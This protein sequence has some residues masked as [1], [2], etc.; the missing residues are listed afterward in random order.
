LLLFVVICYNGCN[1]KKQEGVAMRLSQLNGLVLIRQYG[2]ISKAAQE[3]FQSQSALSVAIKELE[4]ELGNTILLRTKKGVTFTP[5]GLQVL[6]HVDRIFAEIEM[7]R[8]LEG[9]VSSVH[10]NIVLG[11]S[12]YFTNIIATD[13][14]ME[15]KERYP[16]INL[17][18]HQDKNVNTISN[19]L[20]GNLDIGLLQVGAIDDTRYYSQELLKSK[21][22][23]HPL[24]KRPMVFAVSEN[25]PLRGR[26]VLHLTDL[27][28]YCYVTNKNL[29][30]DIAYQSLKA[31]GYQN[32]VIQ[33][34]DT[35]TRPLLVNTNGINVV[36]DIGLEAGN[37]HYQNKLYPLNV[38][39]FTA[40][41]TVGWIH[42]S[43]SLSE[44]EERML[45]ILNMQI[46]QFKE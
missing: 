22:V 23:F 3:S 30:E 42:K 34:N 7:I 14:W 41:Y 16:G 8:E 21:L 35:I 6:E 32:D 36:M 19:V 12:S 4:E 5:Y 18:I 33:V 11:T 28:P 13:L 2:S 26:Q 46:R 20:L 43:H 17:K 38:I 45:E 39:D 27:F 31:Q 37:Q 40:T 24:F 1:K 10:G 9:S 25:H 29:A 15:L 44:A